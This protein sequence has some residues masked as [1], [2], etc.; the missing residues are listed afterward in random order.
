MTHLVRKLT[1]VSS[2]DITRLFED[3]KSKILEGTL[4]FEGAPTEA[5]A[6]V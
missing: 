6:Q 2:D 5:D 4:P 1:S 3:C